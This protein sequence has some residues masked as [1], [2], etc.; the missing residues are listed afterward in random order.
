M[1]PS[2]REKWTLREKEILSS[3]LAEGTAYHK[4]IDEATT[5]ALKYE[6]WSEICQE[7]CALTNSQSVEHQKLR[8]LW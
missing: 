8:D 1:S 6:V 7:F 2:I 5:N 3:L 4:R